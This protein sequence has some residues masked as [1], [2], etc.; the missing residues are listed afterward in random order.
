M[1]QKPE[2]LFAKKVDEDLKVLGGV[3]FNIQQASINGT[4]DRLGCL[5]GVFVALEL[6]VQNNDATRLQD[7]YLA[8]IKKHKGFSATVNPKNWDNI[9]FQLK[10]IKHGGDYGPRIA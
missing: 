2:T 1:A 4:P 10:I 5:N 9:L 7:F 3:W 8:Q 6:K